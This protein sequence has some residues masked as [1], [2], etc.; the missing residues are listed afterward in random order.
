MARLAAQMN[1]T[2]AKS[3]SARRGERGFTL[4]EMMVVVLIMGLVGA[5][6]VPR[7]LSLQPG[8]RLNGAARQ[9]FGEI[10]SARAKAVNENITYTI[11][12]PNDHIL[13]IA[14]ST[15]RSVNLRTLFSSDVTVSSTASTIQLSSR[16]S[17][18]AASTITITN[19]AG[20]KTVSVKI[21]GSATI[22]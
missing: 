11:T 14:G 20:S 19:S 22:S 7:Y 9:V 3:T 4:M 17:S 21:T 12:F 5:V 15:T 18:S 1:M 8:F 16:G 2:N 10:M 6:G 13:Q